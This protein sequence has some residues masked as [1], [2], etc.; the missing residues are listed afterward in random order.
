MIELERD[1]IFRDEIQSRIYNSAHK[2]YQEMIQP[3]DISENIAYL[4][5]WCHNNL[6]KALGSY[7]VPFTFSNNL[8]IRFKWLTS[9]FSS[10]S[11][12]LVNGLKYF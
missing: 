1:G 3:F 4:G 9:A 2:I 8:L 7:S 6:L 11:F 10:R 12:Y 5:L